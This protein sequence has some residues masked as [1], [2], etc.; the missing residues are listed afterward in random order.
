MPRSETVLQFLPSGARI[1]VIR[2]RS[3]GDCVLTTPA[4]ELLKRF[5]SDLRVA[6]SVED[7][8]RAVFDGNPDIE[9]VLPPTPAAAFG[10]RP[11]LCLNLHGGTR[12]VLLT[13]ASC[14]RYRA[15]FGHYRALAAYNIRIPRA[16]V[17]LN[18]D[19]VVHTAEHLASAML[20]LGV[21]ACEIPR[22]RLFVNSRAPSDAPAG[23]YAV[24]H[25]VASS[26]DKT[27]PA[28]HF[29]SLADRLAAGAGLEP[30]FIGAGR[31]DTQPFRRFRTVIGAPL[32]RVKRLLSGAAL[33]IGNDSGPA[34][35]A[36]AFGLPVVVLFGPSDPRIWGPWRTCSE[37]LVSP[38]GI[39]AITVEQVVEAA[40]RLRVRV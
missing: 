8:F 7:R 32:E 35:M 2:L 9:A 33:F 11:D 37:A 40:E 24:L 1:L 22:G 19:R 38:G 25:P 6:V 27:W 31:D 17:I 36:A 12:S 28:A 3:L 5:R 15:G 10:W 14:A 23:P 26:P 34:H 29:L 13:L 21:P 4:L 39:V 18:A 30:V 16:Q 20:Y